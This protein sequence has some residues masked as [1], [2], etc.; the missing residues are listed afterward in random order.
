[1]GWMIRIKAD[2][3]TADLTRDTMTDTYQL[4]KN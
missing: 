2:P 4:P 1:M 3:K